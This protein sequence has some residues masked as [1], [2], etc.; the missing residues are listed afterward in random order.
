VL[1]KIFFW[2]FLVLGFL[3]IGKM[4][5]AHDPKKKPTL[6][7]CLSVAQEAESVQDIDLLEVCS[8]YFWHHQQHDR[9]RGSYNLMLK[10]DSRR[11]V[12]EP[13]N[14]SLWSQV[15]WILW[16]KWVMWKNNPQGVPPGFDGEGKDEEAIALL[17]RGR[18][19]H[20]ENPLYHWE[21]GLTIYRLARFHA[22]K[23]FPFAIESFGLAEKYASDSEFKVRCRLLTADSYKHMG[24]K[25]EAINWYRKVL[26]IDPENSSAKE[27]IEKLKGR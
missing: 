14:L 13:E 11:L 24:K 15:A 4:A 5:L 22:P 10:L 6:E 26:E 3:C 19:H 23:H 27:G 17:T 8:E 2:S 1:A 16:S 7:T 9:P 25:E 20:A 18:S 21:A 12:L